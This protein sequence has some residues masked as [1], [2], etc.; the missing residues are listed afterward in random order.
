MLSPKNA[1]APV[2]PSCCRRREEQCVQGLRY[3]LSD[4][5]PHSERSIMSS[6]A[7]PPLAGRGEARPSAPPPRPKK[8][9]V[10][11]ELPTRSQRVRASCP[12][13]WADPNAPHSVL[14]TAPDVGNII[15]LTSASQPGQWLLAPVCT[16][17]LWIRALLSPSLPVRT[18]ATL[19]RL[20]RTRKPGLTTQAN[21]LD[22]VP[23]ARFLALRRRCVQPGSSSS[24]VVP[25][26]CA[27]AQ[28]LL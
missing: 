27:G 19:P 10:C 20:T 17:R 5:L 7:T 14:K 24:S 15:R 8:G 1:S 25:V 22:V 3:G 12:S 26:V 16:T 28:E 11:S 13:G 21:G 9:A 6:S 23:H 4:P 18:Q 2:I